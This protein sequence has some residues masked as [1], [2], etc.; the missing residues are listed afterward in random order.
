MNTKF[1][2]IIAISIFVALIV[3]VGI[4]YSINLEMDLKM[5]NI[6]PIDSEPDLSPSYAP[7][8]YRMLQ[9]DSIFVAGPI[10]C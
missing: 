4:I 9:F 1:L 10:S 6:G 2:I 5:K 3:F 8:Y 7:Y